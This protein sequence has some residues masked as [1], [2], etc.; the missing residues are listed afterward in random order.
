M[1]LKLDFQKFYLSNMINM[2]APHTHRISF[3][4]VDTNES[5]GRNNGVSH[6]FVVCS[7]WF[8]WDTLK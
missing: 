8:L 5:E 6:L 3:A 2:A 4:Y 7:N 1:W